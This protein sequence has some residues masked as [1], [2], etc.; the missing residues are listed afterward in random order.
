MTAGAL[1]A[2][3]RAASQRGLVMPSVDQIVDA[4]GASRSRAYEIKNA[5]VALLSGLDRPPGRPRAAAAP[6]DAPKL[7]ALLELT[8]EALCFVMR[9]PGCVQ[10]GE[11][12][13]Y[14][15]HYRR[16]VIELRERHADVTLSEF[17]EVL[18]L[19]LGTLEDWL[20]GARP[21]V[22]PDAA[23]NADE[24]RAAAR[25]ARQAQIVETIIQK[26]GFT[27]VP[28]AGVRGL[29]GGCHHRS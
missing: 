14:S 9:H 11:R 17:A 5:V 8:A 1:L 26:R 19:P 18:T 24:P 21:T 29:H 15:D 3:H 13:R 12:A 4:M 20:R 23:P 7:A 10:S 6:A 22:E 2:V 16:F 28:S 27:I 25:D